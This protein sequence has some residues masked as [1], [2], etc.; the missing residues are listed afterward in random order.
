MSDDTMNLRSLVEKSADADLRRA[1]IM[2]NAL[3]HA[4]RSGLRL[5][6]AFIAAAFAQERLRSPARNGAVS[7]I[8]SGRR[9]QNWLT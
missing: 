3:A 5:V 1:H 9:C 2:R 6:S 7:L 8:K 4:G